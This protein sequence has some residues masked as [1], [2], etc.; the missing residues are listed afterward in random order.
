MALVSFFELLPFHRDDGLRRGLEEM[1]VEATGDN[2][3]LDTCTA[4]PHLLDLV[5]LQPFL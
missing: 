1:G 4:G 5:E 2:I 3:G